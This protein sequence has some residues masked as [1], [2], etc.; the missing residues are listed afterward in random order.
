MK[1]LSRQAVAARRRMAK[2]KGLY[3]DDLPPL[4]NPQAAERWAEAVGRA[5]ASGRLTHA[6][7]RAVAALLR[8]WRASYEAGEVEDQYRELRAQVDRLMGKRPMKVEQ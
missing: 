8:E 4:T 2:G 1:E 6:Q 7:G 5:V 3:A